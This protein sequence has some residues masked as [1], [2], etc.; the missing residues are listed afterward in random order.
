M[1]C[2]NI[3]IPLK[4]EYILKMYSNTKQVPKRNEILG[5]I[6]HLIIVDCAHFMSAPHTGGEHRQCRDP[7]VW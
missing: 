4:I 2:S 1:I 5:K 7:R 6:L 3:D